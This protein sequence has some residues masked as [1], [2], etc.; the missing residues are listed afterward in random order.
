MPRE[1]IVVG[2]PDL[3][4]DVGNFWPR[5]GPHGSKVNRS[6]AGW[7][8]GAA[9]E[10]PPK[11]HFRRRRCPLWNRQQGPRRAVTGQGQSIM[12]LGG[13]KCAIR[14][15]LTGRTPAARCDGL[16]DAD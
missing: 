8:Q 13:R 12:G 1:V 11:A 16:V 7:P 14:A 10:S 2:L 15:E 3:R 5:G 9:T 4:V 6:R